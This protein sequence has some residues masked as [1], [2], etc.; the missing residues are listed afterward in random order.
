MPS[1]TDQINRHSE[2]ARHERADLD[3][4][5]D[6][7]HHVATL[8]TVVGGSPWVVPMLYGRVGDRILLHGSV[9][10]GALR[11]VAAGTP[12]ALCVVHLDGWVYAHTLFDSSANYRS[13]VVHGTLV[14]LSGDEAARALT[15]ISECVM[16]GRSAEVPP[17]TKK[18]IAA[19]TALAMDIVPGKWTVKVRASGPGEPAE[20]EADPDLWTGVLPV[21]SGYGEPQRS[22]YAAP[23]VAVS[24]SVLGALTGLY[25]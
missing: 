1:H 25:R 5:L 17:H 9:G 7:P 22:D 24:P 3:A 8:S 18:Q 4:V 23:A 6:V 12:A 19:T 14:A 21:V 2:R 10:A 15:Q 16:P 20:G 13:A 11:H